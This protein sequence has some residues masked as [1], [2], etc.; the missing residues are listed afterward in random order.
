MNYL[1]SKIRRGILISDEH[2]TLDEY[3]QVKHIW[4]QSNQDALRNDANFKNLKLQLNFYEDADAIIR[5]KGRV[6][7]YKLPYDT[8][9]PI[10]LSRNHKLSELIIRECHKKVMH[11]GIKQ[12][13]TE[14]RGKY[15]IIR[16]RSFVKKLISS[17]VTFKRIHGRPYPYP[18][19]PELPAERLFEGRPFMAIGVDHCRPIFIK[20]I[21][22]NEQDE[23]ELNK[24]SIVLYTCAATRGVVLEVVR[25]TSSAAFL[26]SFRRFISRR[27]CPSVII[28]DNSSPFI[29]KDTQDFII[30]RNVTWK[31][32]GGFF[33]RL[34]AC[35]KNCIKKTVGRATLR[36]DEL[37]TVIR[38]VELTINSRPLGYVYDENLEEAITPNHVLYG[39]KI[40]S[41]NTEICL[42]V[43]T[44]NPSRRLKYMETVILHFWN[45]WRPEYLT[46]LREYQKLQNTRKLS[47]ISELNHIVIINDDKLPRHQ[48]RLGRIIELIKGR[49][50]E[51]RAVKL[52]VGKSR[53]V[54]DRPINL[55]YP[56]EYGIDSTDETSE[57]NSSECQNVPVNRN[58]TSNYVSNRPKRNAAVMGELKRKL[59][60]KL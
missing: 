15:W 12:T 51:I 34:V 9:Y 40:N 4:L 21:Y 25:N 20:G 36:Y 33:E 30:E 2:L 27:G 3:N 60:G 42:T 48:W 26:D 5:S 44:I 59:G 23:D 18:A 55:V 45:R 10:M 1:K 38:E 24:C 29:A 31:W 53:S 39:R 54:I 11:R 43:T 19:T 6:G 8:K 32:T 16:G 50:G 49:D 7:S 57:M 13:L 52:L 58:E 47:R 14:L 17:C 35:V 56:I 41:S 37:Q 22:R 28:S 46:S